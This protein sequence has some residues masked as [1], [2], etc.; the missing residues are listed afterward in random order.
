[1][2]RR[3]QQVR[4]IKIFKNAFCVKLVRKNIF[5]CD[6]ESLQVVKGNID[7]IAAFKE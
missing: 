1:M 7:L 2:K 4:I 6:A 5:S 3:I